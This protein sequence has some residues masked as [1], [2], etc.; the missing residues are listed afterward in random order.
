MG[1]AVVYKR[2][3]VFGLTML[4]YA[5][6]VALRKSLRVMRVSRCVDEATSIERVTPRSESS[7]AQAGEVHC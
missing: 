3:K 2:T 5:S 6:H 7:F 4:R 1:V